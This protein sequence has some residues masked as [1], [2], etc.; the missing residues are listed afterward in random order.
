MASRRVKSTIN[1]DYVQA[2]KVEAS[3]V[4]TGNTK[5]NSVLF[6]KQYRGNKRPTNNDVIL[7]AK[8]NVNDFDGIFVYCSLYLNGKSRNV[9]NVKFKISSV[10]ITGTWVE[11]LIAEEVSLDGKLTLST[12]DLLPAALDGDI[13]LAIEAS[14]NIRNKKY[15]KKIYVNHLGI[16]ENVFRLRQ[17]VEFLDITKEDE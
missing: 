11:T 15:S 13:T 4:F 7:A 5:Y 16:Y 17:D 1:S 12:A 3:L 8:F 9:S 14:F 6:T 10:D 2:L